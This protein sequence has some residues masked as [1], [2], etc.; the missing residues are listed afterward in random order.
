MR[1]TAGPIFL[2]ALLC[3]L[4]GRVLAQGGVV[5]S[6]VGNVFD[7]TGQPLKGVK[8]VARSET[9][10]GGAKTTYTSDDG[11]FRFPALQ[12][13]DF[14]VT[15]SAPKLKSVHQKGIKVG[16]NAAAEVTLIMEVETVQDEVKVIEKAPIVS[17]TTATVKE[18][19]DEEFMDNLP[20]ENRTAIEQFVGLNSPGAADGGTRAARIRGGNNNQNHFMVDGFYQNGQRTTFKSLSAMEVQTAGY[21]ADGATAAGGLVT[22]VTKSGS[23]KYELDMNGFWE[24][25][26]LRFF[27]DPSDRAARSWWIVANPNFSGPIIKDR[28]WFY[29]NVEARSERD[30]SDPDPSGF[31]LTPPPK[32]YASVRG[33]GKFTWQISPRNKIQSLNNFNRRRDYNY[34]RSFATQREAQPRRDDLDFFTGLTWESLLTDDIFFKSQ[35]GYTRYWADV[36]PNQCRSLTS[37]DHIIP[38]EQIYPQTIRFQNYDQ[39]WQEK[40]DSVEFVNTLEWFGRSKR[41]GD[42]N[43]KAV[44]RYFHRNQERA[45]STP[46]DQKVWYNG[47]LP[48]RQRLYFSNDPRL[49]PAR[50]GYRIGSSAGYRWTNSLADSMRV[51]RYLTLHPGVAFT[52][53]SSDNSQGETVTGAS[54]ITPHVSVAWDATQDGRTALRAS[55][56]QYVDPDTGRLSRHSLGSR[57]YQECRWNADQEAFVNDCRYSGGTSNRTFGLPCGPTGVDVNGQP[58]RE[59]LKL[60]RT[61]E[62]TVGAEREIVQGVGLG[63]DFVY[64]RFTNPYVTRETNRIWNQSGTALEPTGGFRNGRRETF[65]DLSTPDEAY[66]RYLG[67]TT[68]VHKRE[69]ALKINVSYSWSMLTGNTYD[70]GSWFGN[71]PPRDPFLDSY[72]SDDARHVIRMTQTYQWTRWL[73]TGVTYRYQS[74]RPYNRYFRNS[75]TGNYEDLRAR[76]GINPGS[77]VNDPDDD[78]PLRLPDQQTFNLQGRANLKPLTGLNLELFSDVINVLSLRTTTSVVQD[79]GPR[80][81]QPQNRMSAM[82]VRLGFRFK[83]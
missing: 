83:Y 69:G 14:D 31:F 80:W 21:G 3:A 6:I 28:L 73:T 9:Q 55:F 4:P 27:K 72:L 62:Y 61:W 36:Q 79:D 58:C 56:N 66:R 24:D 22:M 46:G 41:F 67:V 45:E 23:N 50:F 43:V 2:T 53:T 71:I 54:A 38:L 20:M 63:T 40:A 37:C 29:F 52:S 13:G 42:H 64:R 35:V 70:E 44:S 82:K 16:V 51:G 10:I 12:P 15:A 26:Y 33:T 77:N 76:L 32:I 19:Y 57:V 48:D 11:F 47:Q 25:S 68:A 1:W 59:K 39:H 49:E 81:S 60:P 7:Q 18:I 8:V 75:E 30:E 65:S 74:G 5:G 34:D 17:T 78:R